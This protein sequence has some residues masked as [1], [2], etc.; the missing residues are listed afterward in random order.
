MRSDFYPLPVGA[1]ECFAL[2]DGG[3][4]YTLESMVMNAPR[5]EVEAYLQAHGLCT[6]LINTPYTYLY[7]NT[8][9]TV[10]HPLH[11]ERPDWVPV[12]DILTEL[13]NVSKQQ[14]FDWAAVTQSLV[15]GQHFP[16]FPNVGYV[17]KKGAGWTWQPIEI[18]PE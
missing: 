14:I 8:G 5:A 18:L 2:C 7:V 11:L 1:F 17:A 4:D 10:L 16:P 9:D 6:D 13:A 12:Y 3:A 15:L